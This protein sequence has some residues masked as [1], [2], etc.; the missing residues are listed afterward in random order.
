MDLKNILAILTV[1]TLGGALA[2][3]ASAAEETKDSNGVASFETGDL[4]LDFVSS[5]DFG[6]H[7]IS[8]NDEIYSAA[9]QQLDD[10]RTVPNYAQVTD[11]RGTGNGWRLNVQQQSQFIATKDGK[12]LEGAQIQ[13]ENGVVTSES[14]NAPQDVTQSV[15]LTP[16]VS[17]KIV[18]AN[19]NEGTGTW[20]YGLGDDSTKEE[21]VHLAVPGKS[22]K[23]ADS[24]KTI[25][26]WALLDA[27]EN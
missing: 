14:T 26:T 27:P 8:K 4:T 1:T 11:L 6:N 7:P 9:A 2:T 24:Y 25:L 22:F 19:E 18:M 13:F 16:G 15:N 3:T 20:V 5:F 10:G 12:E 17:E 21:S 23:A